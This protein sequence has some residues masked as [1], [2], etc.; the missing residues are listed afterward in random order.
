[1]NRQG[2]STLVFNSKPRV[3]GNYSVVGPKEGRGNFAQY[4]DRIL[5][6]DTLGQPTYEKAE[7]KLLEL[8]IDGAISNAKLKPSQIDCMVA[9]DLMN[10]I[11]SSSFAARSL[12]IPYL[13]V[14]GACSTMAE[15]LMVGATLIDGKYANNVVCATVSHFSSA[16]K[17]FRYPL[18]LGTQRPP[19]SQWTTTGSGATVLAPNNNGVAITSATVGKVVDWNVTDVNNMGGAMAPAAF[20]TLYQHLNDLNIEPDYYDLILTGD[21]GKLGSEVLID[22]MENKGVHLGANYSDCGQMMFKNTQKVFMGASGCGCGASVLN[23]YVLQRLKN[24]TLK[25][26]LFIATGALLSPLTCQ[27]GESIPCIA[28]AVVL[29]G[30]NYV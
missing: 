17:Q 12:N 23:S 4:F 25:R 1:M 24:R 21:L 7:C 30:E 16:E 15:S 29:K 22:L 5:E 10:Q 19:T 28:H 18:E 8:C 20:E 9:G 26:V 13:G 2:K 14:F 27:Q 6:D 3:I 11:T